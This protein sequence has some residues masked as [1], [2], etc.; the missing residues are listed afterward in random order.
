MRPPSIP[1]CLSRRQARLM[2]ALALVVLCPPKLSD[3]QGPPAWRLIEEQRWSGDS[4]LF[5]RLS[6]ILP[7]SDGSILVPEVRERRVRAFAADGSFERSIGRDG[8]GPGEFVRLNSSGLL[9]DTLWVADLNL[10][11]TSLFLKNGELLSTLPWKVLVEGSGESSNLIS[12]LFADGTA[13]GEKATGAGAIAGPELPKAILRLGRSAEMLDTLAV[14]S[15]AHTLYSV[16]DGPT[17]SFGAQPFADAPL[18]VGSSSQSRVYVIDRSAAPN[19]RQGVIQIAAINARG[20]TAWNRA[21]PYVP[22]PLE[23][24]VADS[25]LERTHRGLRRSRASLEVVRRVLFLP[26]NRPP[27]SAGISASD[28][29]LWLRREAGQA[30]VQYWVVS[31]SGDLLGSLTV[32]SNVSIAA[33]SRS[34]AWGITL[35]ADDVPSIVRFRIVR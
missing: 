3:A 10:R 8:Q 26:A 19:R 28:G 25:V 2:L 21:Y 32:A 23:R 30:Q 22:R 24:R 16:M 33:A 35:D 17:I 12:G 20:D 31:A 27:V 5:T 7:T 13:W 14:V 9:G 18:V 1:A 4:H 29:T 34:H 15:T 11:R 6:A